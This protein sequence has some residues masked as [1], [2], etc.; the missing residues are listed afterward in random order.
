MGSLRRLQTDYVDTL[1]IH[2]PLVPLSDNEFEEIT[3]CA[4]TLKARGLL[5]EFGFAGALSPNSCHLAQP[6]LDVIQAPIW[7]IEEQTTTD[8]TA[9][10]VAYGVYRHYRAGSQGTDFAEYLRGT[11][12]RLGTAQIILSTSKRMR[13]EEFV[14]AVQ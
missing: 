3:A 10:P 12:D 7:D 6:G 11:L 4:R 9:R 8:W 14:R 2:D 1:L 13:L 5:R